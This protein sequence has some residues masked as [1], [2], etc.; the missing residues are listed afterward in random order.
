VVQERLARRHIEDS[1]AHGEGLRLS[2]VLPNRELGPCE[3]FLE[4]GS[5]EDY[6]KLEHFS[7]PR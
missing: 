6:G 1:L 4:R 3:G 5:N 7:I 2:T